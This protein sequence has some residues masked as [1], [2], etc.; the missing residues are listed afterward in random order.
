MEVDDGITETTIDSGNNP[1]FIIHSQIDSGNLLAHYTHGIYFVLTASG[2]SYYYN[3]GYCGYHRNSSDQN[4]LLY[5]FVALPAAGMVFG[6]GCNLFIDRL[7]STLPNNNVSPDGA[8]DSKISVILHELLE[9]SV[10]P[11]PGSSPTWLHNKKENSE[12]GGLCNY[13]FVA[14]E[15]YCCDTLSIYSDFNTFCSQCMA[16]A[17]TPANG[18]PPRSLT[19]PKSGVI[20][21]QYG[22]GE[23]P[24]YIS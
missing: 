13:A 11:Y 10:D 24:I 23:F 8:L 1:V 5:S 19:D 21:N 3:P 22:V 20:F 6:Q 7:S 2:I 17:R 9:L 16:L 4:N 18:N 14:D 15:W 12:I